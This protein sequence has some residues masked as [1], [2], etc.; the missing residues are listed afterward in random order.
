[1][2]TESRS[3]MLR[4]GRLWRHGFVTLLAFALSSCGLS[5]RTEVPIPFIIPTPDGAKSKTLIVMLPGRGDRADSFQKAGFLD[6]LDG[7]DFDVVAVDAHFGYY[8]E[9]SL[10][11]RLHDDVVVPAKDMG[12]ETIWL[13]G[14]SMGGMGSL[15]YADQYPDDISGVILLAPYL[16][17]PG[18]V[19]EIETAGGLEAWTGETSGFMEHET[20]TWKWL[21]ETRRG[22]ESVP[23]YLGFGK[24]DRFAGNYGP[25]QSDVDGLWLYTED[26]GHNWAI[27]SRL[28]SR[29]S[30][31]LPIHN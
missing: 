7:Q 14:V 3:M 30:A 1:M 21:K 26:G 20:A 9:R 25:L 22:E 31:E 16:G 18:L 28:W 24:T 15:L 29:I 27:W 17:D 5:P 13:L 11:R 6:R 2:T 10:T 8:K 19:A 12:Y 23:V 4:L